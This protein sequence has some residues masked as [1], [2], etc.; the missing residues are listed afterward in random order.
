MLA[1]L[2]LCFITVHYCAFIFLRPHSY[3][4]SHWF[5]THKHCTLLIAHSEL[6]RNFNVSSCLVTEV[7]YYLHISKCLVHANAGM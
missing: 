5:A 6:H 2:V 4:L 1:G 7:L 3:F